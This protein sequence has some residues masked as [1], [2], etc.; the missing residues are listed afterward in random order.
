MTVFNLHYYIDQHGKPEPEPDV[1]RWALWYG[2]RHK[3]G[4]NRLRLDELAL[5]D[6]ARARVVYV[7]TI[8]TGIDH[9]PGLGIVDADPMLWETMVFGGP[10]CGWRVRWTS[11]DNAMLGQGM[12]CGLT[13]VPVDVARIRLTSVLKYQS[14]FTEGHPDA[15]QAAM[16]GVPT[17]AEQL[18]AV[19]SMLRSVE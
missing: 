19:K 18:A 12:L 1:V 13:F 10:L 2:R 6:D 8:F 15:I 7:S 5:V 11:R 3:E 16:H 17:P 4:A 9:G 14:A